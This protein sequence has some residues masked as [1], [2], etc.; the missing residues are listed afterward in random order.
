M[1][2]TSYQRQILRALAFDNCPWTI[3][4]GGIE[5]PCSKPNIALRVDPETGELTGVCR[6]HLGPASGIAPL[7]HI[8][9]AIAEAATNPW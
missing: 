4:P 2:L 6:A 9:Q 5:Q 8:V 7:V 3:T 1:S